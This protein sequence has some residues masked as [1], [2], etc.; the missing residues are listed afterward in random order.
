MSTSLKGSASRLGRMA[1]SGNKV[2]ILKLSGMIIGAVIVL[3]LIWGL[4][5]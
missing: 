1:A 4:F 2:A 3:W 5:V